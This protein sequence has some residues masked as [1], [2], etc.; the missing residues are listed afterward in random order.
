MSSLKSIVG[1]A[2]LG[3]LI[4]QPGHAQESE[5]CPYPKGRAVENLAAALKAHKEWAVKRGWENPEVPGRA[6]FCANLIDFPP[7][8][9]RPRLF[10]ECHAP[11][12]S[13]S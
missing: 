9:R 12:G 6:N 3:L 2:L 5:D 11:V 10:L 1:L 7:S 13:Y 4:V 8:R